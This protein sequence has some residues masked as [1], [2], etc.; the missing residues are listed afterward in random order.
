MAKDIVP[1]MTHL[2][3]T[4]QSWCKLKLIRAIELKLPFEVKVAR[5]GDGA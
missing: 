3:G 2:K 4:K 1:G 5:K